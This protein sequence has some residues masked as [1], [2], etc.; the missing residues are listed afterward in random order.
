MDWAL[1]GLREA[2]TEE[3]S[4]EAGPLAKEGAGLAC[5][6]EAPAR[7]AA[8]WRSGMSNSD[9]WCLCSNCAQH[10]NMNTYVRHKA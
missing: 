1:A 8:A 2:V 10:E 6:E 7:A 3:A 4:R 5:R 9:G